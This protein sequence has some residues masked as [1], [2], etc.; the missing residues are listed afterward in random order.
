MSRET[1]NASAVGVSELRTTIEATWRRALSSLKREA[2]QALVD[3]V[4]AP[5]A[6]E[7][8]DALCD[9]ESDD[10]TA[11]GEID[12]DEVVES[13]PEPERERGRTR[14]GKRGGRRRS[15]RPVDSEESSDNTGV[16]TPD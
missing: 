5:Y 4:V 13:E 15:K 6:T 10:E 11:A 2:I 14:R 3:L 9:R 12:D 7:C 1:H 16:E 8:E